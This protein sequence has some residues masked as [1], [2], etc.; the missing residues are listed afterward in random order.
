MSL[1]NRKVAAKISLIS[2]YFLIMTFAVS[3]VPTEG[4]YHP[5]NSGRVVTWYEYRHIM[6]SEKGDKIIFHEPLLFILIETRQ[7]ASYCL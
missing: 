5:H 1:K 4:Y 7:C 6:T 2:L 3:L